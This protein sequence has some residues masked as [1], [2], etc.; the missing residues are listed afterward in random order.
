MKA[1]GTLVCICTYVLQNTF[2]EGGT[3]FDCPSF[4]KHN[5]IKRKPFFTIKLWKLV[6]NAFSLHTSSL[7]DLFCWN[8]FI[9][10]A[11]N[12]RIIE[13]FFQGGTLVDVPTLLSLTQSQISASSTWKFDTIHLIFVKTLKGHSCQW[14][15]EL[16]RCVLIYPN[17]FCYYRL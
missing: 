4:L 10:L 2:V 3:M 17:C 11:Q 1:V 13:F 8:L 14:H 12:V 15:L 7:D 6:L 9:F 5:S 16:R